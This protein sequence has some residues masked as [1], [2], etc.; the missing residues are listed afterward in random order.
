VDPGDAAAHVQL[1][2]FLLLNGR[3]EEALAEARR[4]EALDPFSPVI[5]SWVAHISLFMGKTDQAL[6]AAKRGM[7]LDSTTAPAIYAASLA[8]LVAGNNKAAIETIDRL[9][10]VLPWPGFVALVHASAGDPETAKRIVREIE[11][12]PR[13]WSAQT[14]L[15]WA[16]LGLKDT[17]RALDALE[18]ATDYHEMW[19]VWYSLGYRLYDPIRG[20]ARFA[21]L[22]RRVGLD[23]KV[24]NALQASPLR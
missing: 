23:E 9:P 21:A 20:S 2:R 15:A 16:Y 1:A 14:T 18:R 24:I 17:T 19:F 12:R 4:A 5:A 3:A 7:E 8:Y 11:S 22:V 10:N 6:A 13:A